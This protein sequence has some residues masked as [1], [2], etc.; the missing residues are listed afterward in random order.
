MLKDHSTRRILLV[1]YQHP[2]WFISLEIIETCGLLLCHVQIILK[3]I[4]SRVVHLSLFQVYWQV[5]IHSISNELWLLTRALHSFFLNCCHLDLTE[6]DK[7][8]Y[9]NPPPT[10]QTLTM[11][12]PICNFIPQM[13]LQSSLWKQCDGARILEQVC[14]HVH[15][16]KFCTP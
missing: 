11:D 14:I 13:N 16:S 12:M 6:V 15:L 5:S 4:M 10:T 7:T 8:S 3:G 9:S 1:F 2:V